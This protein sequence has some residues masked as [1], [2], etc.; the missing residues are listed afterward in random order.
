MHHQDEIPISFVTSTIGAR[1]AR[2]HIDGLRRALKL[3]DGGTKKYV[4]EAG[5]RHPSRQFALV[6]SADPF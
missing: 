3:R 1:T 5:R 6:V 2:S 4:S